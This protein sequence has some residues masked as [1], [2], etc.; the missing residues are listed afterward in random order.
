MELQW[1]ESGGVFEYLAF[2]RTSVTGSLN[3]PGAQAA[4]VPIGAEQ[5]TREGLR[6][7]H[8]KVLV[9]HST[10]GTELSLF[11][12]LFVSWWCWVESKASDALGKCF[13][14]EPCNLCWASPPITPKAA[15]PLLAWVYSLSCHLCTVLE[16]IRLPSSAVLLPR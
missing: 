12:F 1:W 5:G 3:R 15:H 13:P 6:C 10:S 9:V 11:L 4:H 16:L 14:T 7:S 2:T 8:L